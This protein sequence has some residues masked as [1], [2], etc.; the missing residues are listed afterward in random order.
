MQ[1]TFILVVTASL[2]LLTCYTN[3]GISFPDKKHTEI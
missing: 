1:N 3:G 2:V